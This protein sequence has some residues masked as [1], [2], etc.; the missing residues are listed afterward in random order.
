MDDSSDPAG[1]FF[2]FY[3]ILFTGRT[4]TLKKKL[5]RVINFAVTREEKLLSWLQGEKMD[6]IIKV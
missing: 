6:V 5:F 2:W 1:L 4:H 3:G